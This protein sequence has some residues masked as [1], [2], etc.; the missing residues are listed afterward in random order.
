MSADFRPAN[1]GEARII[2]IALAALVIG[3]ACGAY[4]YYRQAQK[5]IP[6]A[7]LSEAQRLSEAT[8]AI[9]QRLDAPV[10]ISLYAP[11]SSGD[12][13]EAMAVFVA[14]VQQLL[15]EY[16]RVAGDKIRLTQS[17]PATS[18]SAKAAAG[19]DG[20]LPLAD[21]NGGVFYLGIAISQRGRKETMAQLSPDWE[22]ALESDLSRA[23][24]RVSAST[25]TP[26]ARRLPS[27]Q[28]TR[29]PRRTPSPSAASTEYVNA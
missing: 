6:E 7:P 11:A 14:R 4:W 8:Q 3:L 9:L 28:S 10:E 23:I 1:R 19:V 26:T 17:D 29:A 22:A 15:S 21:N 5:Q 27:S 24:A 16:Q 2:I 12:L 18:A 25:A 13:S 20:L